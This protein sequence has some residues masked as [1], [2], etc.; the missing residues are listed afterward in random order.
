M[1][2]KVVKVD[3]RDHGIGAPEDVDQLLP[4]AEH[5]DAE[6]LDALFSER[7]I[8]RLVHAGFAADCVDVLVARRGSFF[9][10]LSD[11]GVL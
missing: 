1:L 11:R 7:C 3:G 6:H 8:L 5:V 9:V 4:R 2:L 10:V